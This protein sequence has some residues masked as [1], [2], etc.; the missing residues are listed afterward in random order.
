VHGTNTII[1]ERIKWQE[2][3][4]CD[5]RGEFNILGGDSV[6][7]FEKKGSREHLSDFEWLPL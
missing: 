4:Q 6:S 3:I 1:S 2:Y 5:S 7:Y